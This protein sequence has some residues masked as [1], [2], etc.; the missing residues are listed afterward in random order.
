[1][2]KVSI[3][4]AIERARARMLYLILMVEQALRSMLLHHVFNQPIIGM[5]W[6]TLQA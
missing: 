2:L 1:M 5:K 4:T 3:V 6:V